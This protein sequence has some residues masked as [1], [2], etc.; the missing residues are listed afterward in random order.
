MFFSS[1]TWDI[2]GAGNFGY[3]CVWVNRN[4]NVFDLLDYNPEIIISDLKQVLKRLN[5]YKN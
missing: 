5:F 1:N 2:S 4:K 3:N